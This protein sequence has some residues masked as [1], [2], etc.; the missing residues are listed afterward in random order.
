MVFCGVP[1]QKAAG[2]LWLGGEERGGK[3]LPYDEGGGASLKNREWGAGS[4]S[5]GEDCGEQESRQARGGAESHPEGASRC[6]EKRIWEI[7]V[8]EELCS[9]R[10]ARG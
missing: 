9:H 3:S 10:L 2:T 6:S 8:W 7:R 1:N 5:A 4:T